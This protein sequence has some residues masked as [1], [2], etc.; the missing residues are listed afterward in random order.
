MKLD[1]PLRENPVT[2]SHNGPVFG[3][4]RY[5]QCIRNVVNR[6]GMVADDWKGGGD[7]PENIAAIV[8]NER[9]PS[10]TCFRRQIDPAAVKLAYTLMSEAD[11]RNRNIFLRNHIGTNAEVSPF[12]RPSRPR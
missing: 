2:D 5:L 10:M 4:R 8:P 1:S 3:S 7:V 12:V 6:E 11:S 9:F